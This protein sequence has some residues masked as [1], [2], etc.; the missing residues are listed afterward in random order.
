HAEPHGVTM[1]T[2]G[3]DKSPEEVTYQTIA[4]QIKGMTPRALTAGSLDDA[5][6]LIEFMRTEALKRH[7]ANE[8]RTAAL[9]LR[10]KDI[11]IRARHLALNARAVNALL[12]PTGKRRIANLWR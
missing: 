12:H 10:E 8:T 7:D 11:N 1:T 5:I 3:E 9:D 2:F 4:A 6:T